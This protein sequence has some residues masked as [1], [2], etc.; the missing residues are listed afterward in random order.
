[1][2]NEAFKKIRKLCFVI[3]KLKYFAVF[4]E[5][6][7]YE[8]ETVAYPGIFLGRGGGGVTPGIF[9]RGFNKF[10]SGKRAEKT[11]I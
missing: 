8:W 1:L 3:V 9:S 10:S 4:D 5:T 2:I 6:D 11:G 7:N